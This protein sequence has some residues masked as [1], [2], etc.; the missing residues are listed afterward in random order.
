M[1]LLNYIKIKIFISQFFYELFVC[2]LQN[3]AFLHTLKIPLTLSSAIFWST[4]LYSKRFEEKMSS[5]W[6]QVKEEEERN[7]MEKRKKKELR[8]REGKERK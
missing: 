6:C 4:E 7:D 3:K 8:W 5:K 2:N 1:E